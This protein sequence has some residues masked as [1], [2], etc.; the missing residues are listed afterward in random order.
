[1]AVGGIRGGGRGVKGGGKV[2]G[3][4]APGKTSGATAG[5]V[6][7][8]QGLVGP[9]S[10]AGSG[11]VGSVDPVSAQAMAIA[12]ALKTGEIATRAE[13][14]E[15]LVAGILRERLRVQLSKSL[16]KKISEHLQDDPR[17]SQTLDRIW[18]KG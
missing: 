9:S 13:A 4:V 3:K 1:M 16:S 8:F 15:K 11:E 17:L 6:D 18:T 7:R 10:A 14:T 5:K 12:K 2:G